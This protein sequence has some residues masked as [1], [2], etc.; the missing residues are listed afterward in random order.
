MPS[1]ENLL[2][3]PQGNGLTIA[4]HGLNLGRVALAAN[5]AGV[6]RGLL[7]NLI[8]WAHRRLTFG[9]AIGR[10]ELVQRRLARLAGLIVG[11]DALVHWC[12]GLL[13]EGYRGEMECVVAKVF[14][15]EAQKEAAIELFMK[16]HGGRS[17]LHGHRFGDNVHEYLAPCIYEGE[18]EMLGLALFKSLVK[19]HGSTYLEPIAR[20]LREAGIDRPNPWNP[21]HAWKLRRAATPYVRWLAAQRLR[22]PPRAELAE[23]SAPLKSHAE[24]AYCQLQRAP[25]E[26]SAAMRKHHLTLADRQLRMSEI[27][28]RIQALIVQLCT[29]VHAGGSESDVV[30]DAGAVLCQELNRRLTGHRPTDREFRALSGLGERLL[31]GGYR[32]LTDVAAD[33]LLMP[34]GSGDDDLTERPEPTD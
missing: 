5:A 16:T 13:D 30:R 12:A 22:R 23:L 1:A 6:M 31:D 11:C 33:P 19:H 3:P 18:G 9:A 10:R 27:S 21:V 15:S 17:F 32:E 28:T 2:E 34:Y 24:R 20:A 4:Y 14:A 7:A 26:I 29:S 8:P 25:L